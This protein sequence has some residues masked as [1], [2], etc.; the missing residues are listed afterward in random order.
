MQQVRVNT[1]TSGNGRLTESGWFR[2]TGPSRSA[3]LRAQLTRFYRPTLSEVVTLLSVIGVG[4]VLGFIARR[5][6]PYVLP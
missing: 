6:A 3:R 4:A 2:T 1:P 5:L